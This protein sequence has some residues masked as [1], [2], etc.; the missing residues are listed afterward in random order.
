MMKKIKILCVEDN[1]G[2]SRLISELLINHHPVLF[3]ILFT[4]S[5]EGV[6]SLAKDSKFDA[7]LLDLN[8]PDSSGLSTVEEIQVILPNTPLIVISGSSDEEITE[9][10]L[11]N[12]VQDHIDKNNLTTAVLTNAIKYAIERTCILKKLESERQRFQVLIEEHSDG[13]IVVNHEGIVKY[14]N[15]ACENLL[16][17]SSEE[18]LNQAFG[19]PISTG[20]NTEISLIQ[21][22]GNIIIVEMRVTEIFW[23]EEQCYLAALRDITLRKKIERENIEYSEDLE[24]ANFNKDK[25]FSIIAHDLRSPFQGLLTL[26]AMMADVKENFTISELTSFSK[27]LNESANNLYQLLGNLLE[28]AMMQKGSMEFT[29]CEIN[30]SEIVKQNIRLMKEKA[31]QKGIIFKNEVP[32]F[33]TVFADEKMTE[34]ILRNLISN[35]VKFTKEDGIITLRSA[36]ADNGLIEI[37]VSDTGIGMTKEI[38]AKLFRIGEKIGTKGTSGEPSTGL[39]LILCKEFV[40][41]HG[42]KIWAESELSK[43]STFRFTLPESIK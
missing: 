37:S 39:G 21:K 24:K 22:G 15:K 10:T 7:I 43:G 2:D 3:D 27:S 29:Q 40:E 4:S 30:F 1:P 9:K 17:R 26:T 32:E 16:S 42:G 31:A 20:E 41:K 36:K 35:A 8:L 5:I 33:Q 14:L 38:I 13:V 34:T 19:F 25:F 12:G 28:W 23:S 11:Q 18:L 6:K